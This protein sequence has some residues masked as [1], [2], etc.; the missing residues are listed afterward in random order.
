MNAE[1][2]VKGFELSIAK[3]SPKDR[4]TLEMVLGHL[5]EAAQYTFGAEHPKA[6]AY[7]PAKVVPEFPKALGKFDADRKLVAIYLAQSLGTQPEATQCAPWLP[8]RGVE[9]Y[10]ALKAQGVPEWS[11][12]DEM[13]EFDRRMAEATAG[14]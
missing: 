9:E 10:H 11:P 6:P 3:A 1:D 12:L 2:F 14:R 5:K 4:A 13:S 7:V 8:L